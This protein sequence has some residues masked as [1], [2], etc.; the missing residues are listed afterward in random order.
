MLGGHAL[1]LVHVCCP[2]LQ[3]ELAFKQM[4]VETVVMSAGELESEH[5]GQPGRLIRERYRKAAELSKVRG[6][7]SCLMI[8]DLDAGIG[9][10]SN[11]QVRTIKRDQQFEILIA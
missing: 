9:R 5:A 3:T 2:L 6:K 8:N 10:F 4:G 7:M 1:L 11:T